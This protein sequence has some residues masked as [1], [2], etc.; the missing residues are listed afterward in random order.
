MKRFPRLLPSLSREDLIQQGV[1]F[2]LERSKKPDPEWFWRKWKIV[3]WGLRDYLKSVYRE[4]GRE[5]PGE[6]DHFVSSLP[7]FDPLFEWNDIISVC[8]KPTQKLLTQFF[9]EGKRAEDLAKEWGLETPQGVYQRLYA[10]YEKLQYVLDE[11][12]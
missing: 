9:Y 3:L 8:D 4:S 10:A 11:N 5:V 12:V 7:S 6:M 1:L 2:Y